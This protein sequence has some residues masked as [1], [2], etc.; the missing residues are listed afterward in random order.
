MIDEMGCLMGKR[1]SFFY[2]KNWAK[3]KTTKNT[4]NVTC[5]TTTDIDTTH[6]RS[7]FRPNS[8]CFRL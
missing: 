3:K 1:I 6:R 4:Y 7:I 5:P 2:E 8:P